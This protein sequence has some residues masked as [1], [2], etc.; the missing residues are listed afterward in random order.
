MAERDRVAQG[1]PL[2][3]PDVTPIRVNSLYFDV[4]K[5]LP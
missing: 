5:T 3:L 2:H 4:T 1:A